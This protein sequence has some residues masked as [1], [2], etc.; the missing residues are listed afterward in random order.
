MSVEAIR[1]SDE[2]AV[3]EGYDRWAA[4]YDRDGN[5]LQALDDVH[6]PRAVGDVSGLRVVEL[7]CGTGRHTLRLAAA[8]A[9]V[10]AVDFS[11]GML[12]EARSKPGADRANFVQHDLSKPLPFE[13]GSFDLVFSALVLEHLAD[14][15]GFFAECAR[16]VRHGGR[17]VVSAMHPAMFLRG[18]QARFT[19][20]DSGEKV[21]PGSYDHG[22]G[23]M[24]MAVVRA[25]LTLEA[26]GEYTPD[27]ELAT[28]VVRAEKHIG[29]PMLV[30]IQA[31]RLA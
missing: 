14:L 2:D 30:V 25:G 23:A 4:V 15:D 26:V 6:T 22:V 5:P 13:N 31:R 21:M 8:G 27:A 10:T 20:P 16:V 17:V 24:V 28:R 12:A 11:E 18:A 7:G 1:P 29:W 19:D 9:A 3:R